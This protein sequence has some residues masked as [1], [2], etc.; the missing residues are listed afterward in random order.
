M[1]QL[2]QTNIISIIILIIIYFSLRKHTK[3]SHYSNRYFFSLLWLNVAVLSSDILITQFNGSATSLGRYVLLSALT[4]YFIVALSILVTWLFYV[5]HRINKRL[6]NI[7]SICV[8][9][10]PILIV[11]LVLLVLSINRGYFFY[12][13]VNGFHQRGEMLIPLIVFNVSVFAFSM[14]YIIFNQK[15]I[16]ISDFKALLFFPVPPILAVAVQL[17][18]PQ[19][20]VLWPSMTLSILVIYIYIQSKITNTDSLTGVFNRREY[21]Y[22]VYNIENNKNTKKTIGAILIDINNFKSINDDMSHQAGD[23]ALIE[24]GRILTKSV[25]KNDFIARIGGDE[26]CVI[27]QIEKEDKL[28]E[29]INR[30]EKNLADYNKK[31]VHDYCLSISMGYGI[32][33]DKY[34]ESM[35]NFLHSLDRKMYEDKAKSKQ[36]LSVS[37]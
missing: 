11:H 27:M 10:G 34:Y 33:H 13:D 5:D 3:A 4:I 37:I 35:E 29:I 24:L 20:R 26:F 28:F 18:E 15:Y 36:N 6:K 23:K 1:I 12:V 30:I 7:K 8:I 19:L 21:E 9:F 31:A 2:N 16:P 17:F 14:V 22:Q 32:Y 25:R